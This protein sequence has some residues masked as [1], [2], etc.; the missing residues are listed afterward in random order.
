MLPSRLRRR[1]EALHSAMVPIHGPEPTVDPDTLITLA[2]AI[3]DRQRLR[4]DYRSHDGATGRRSVEPYRLAHT[5]RR[6][7]L[8]AWDID[9]EAWRTFRVDRLQPRAPTGPGFEPREP[10]DPD[11]GGYTAHTITTGVY[12]YQARITIHGPAEAVAQRITPTIG[13]IEAIDG[14]TCILR[15]GAN[16]LDDLAAWVAVIGFDFQVH[17]PPALIDHLDIVIGRLSRARQASAKAHGKG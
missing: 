7:Y 10:P 14:Q 12:R 6:W 1:V 4:F 8:V 11:I 15:T 5:G 2:A 3:R 13:T 17:E 9:R 16:S